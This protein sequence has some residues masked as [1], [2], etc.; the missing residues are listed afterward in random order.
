MVGG[1]GHPL[2]QTNT[3]ADYTQMGLDPCA[4]VGWTA[5]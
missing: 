4:F 2:F 5:I 1:L 3:I